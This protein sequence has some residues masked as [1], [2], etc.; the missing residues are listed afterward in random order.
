MSNNLKIL[1]ISKTFYPDTHGGVEHFIRS[2]TEASGRL[3]CDNTLVTASKTPDTTLQYKFLNVLREPT[4]VE[5]ASCPISVPLAKKFRALSQQY[6]ILHMHFPWPYADLLTLLNTKKPLIITYHSDIIKQKLIKKFYRPLMQ[7][8]F[9]RASLI[10]PT[11]QNLLES[12]PD[13]KNFKTKCRPIPL[14]LDFKNYQVSDAKRIE[15]QQKIGEGF[16]LFIGQFRYYKGI[17]VLM[18]ALQKKPVPAVFIGDG[19]NKNQ[20]VQ[21]GLT[22]IHFVGSVEDADKN[23]ILSLAK[24][25]VLP[26]IERT[27]AFGI[28]LLEGAAFGKALIST[29][30]NTGTSYANLHEKTGLVVKPNDSTALAQAIDIL[31]NHPELCQLYGENAKKRFQ[32]HFTIDKVAQSYVECYQQLLKT[33]KL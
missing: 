2:L 29:E 18:A 22:N 21:S 13:L 8:L 24:A 19:E 11:S 28:A 3:G 7:N 33:P 14:G 16:L 20:Y 32:N 26:S 10:V 6:D 30:L 25:V 12:S 17:E 23:A 15:W 9:Q 1:H 5:L 27:E 4:T 31:F